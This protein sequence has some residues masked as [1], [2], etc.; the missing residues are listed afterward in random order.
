MN[1]DA[2]AAVVVLDDLRGAGTGQTPSH[3]SALGVDDAHL[4]AR[5]AM[6][7]HAED[8]GPTVLGR[9]VRHAIDHLECFDAPEHVTTVRLTSKEVTSICPVTEQPDLSTL[10]IEYRPDRRCIESKSLKLYLWSF[11]DRKVF[12]EALAA[13]V[14]EEVVRAVDPHE[15]TITVT[16]QPRGGIVIE[17]TATRRRQS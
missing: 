14:A 9:T 10:V 17:A 7:T 4:Y 8:D 12:C 5:T 6:G 3:P 1:I 15:V 13:E 2:V 11:R 16:Q